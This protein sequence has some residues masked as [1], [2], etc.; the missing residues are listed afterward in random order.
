VAVEAQAIT[1]TLETVETLEQ[2]L[3]Q[4]EVEVEAH[5]EQL[6]ISQERVELVAQE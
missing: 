6:L 3:A 5:L 2:T 4:A 1:V